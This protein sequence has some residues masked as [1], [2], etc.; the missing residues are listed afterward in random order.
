MY[1]SSYPSRCAPYEWCPIGFVVHLGVTY[2]LDAMPADGAWRFRAHDPVRR[3]AIDLPSR[4]E[5][6]RPGDA[7]LLPG[8]EAPGVYLAKLD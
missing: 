7:I 1:T 5:P 6:L 4:L 2:P 8:S 3:A